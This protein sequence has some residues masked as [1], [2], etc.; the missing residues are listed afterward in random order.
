ML[1]IAALWLLLFCLLAARPAL[2]DTVP[3]DVLLAALGMAVDGLSL[4]GRTT[5]GMPEGLEVLISAV[6]V[7]A[8]DL[9]AARL[10]RP[11]LAPEMT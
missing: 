4:C 5:F 1:I 8:A 7:P 9:A 11:L 2:G 10:A 6:L 3:V